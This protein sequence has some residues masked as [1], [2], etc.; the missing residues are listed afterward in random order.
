[1][2]GSRV[3]MRLRAEL[4][5]VLRDVVEVVPSD[6]DGTSHLGRHYAAV[7][8]ASTNRDIASERAL[9]VCSPGSNEASK[10]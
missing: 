6:D 3:G 7:Q 5:T 4:L 8:D 1:M 2:A 10:I 9:L